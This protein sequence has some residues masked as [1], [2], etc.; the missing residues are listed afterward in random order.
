MQKSMREEVERM[1]TQFIFKQHELETTNRKPPSSVRPH[2]TFKG[3]P[4]TPM[5]LPSQIRGWN[6]SVANAYQS[7]PTEDI[8]KHPALSGNT[9]YHPKVPYRSP[10]RTKKPNALPG[11]HNAFATS[12]P[13]RPSQQRLNIAKQRAIEETQTRDAPFLSAFNIPVSPPSSPMHHSHFSSTNQPKN[14]PDEPALAPSLDIDKDVDMT[15]DGDEVMLSEETADEVDPVEPFNWKIELNRIILTETLPPFTTP[16]FQNII[17]AVASLELPPDT[18][19]VYSAGCSQILE[20]LSTTFRHNEFKKALNDISHSL[21]TMIPVISNARLH[22][23]LAALYGL[24]TTLCYALPDFSSVLLMCSQDE[25]GSSNIIVHICE[26]IRD[27]MEGS[28]KYAHKEILSKEVV[29]LLEALCFHTKDELINRLVIMPRTQASLLALLHSYQP[30]WLLI[31]GVRLLVLL[32]TYTPLCRTLISMVDT[33]FPHI[34]QVVTPGRSPLVERLCYHLTE[35]YRKDTECQVLKS[36]I[37]TFFALL[38]HSDPEVHSA[39]V[40]SAIFIPTIIIFISQLTTP[41]WDDSE[42]L[43]DASSHAITLAIKTLNQALFLLHYLI[44]NTTPVFNLKQK[45]SSVNGIRHFNGLTHTFIVTFGR[46]CYADTPGWVN[47]EGSRELVL[48]TDMARE[49]LDLVVDGPECDNIWQAY[50]IE[51]DNG[52]QTDEEELEA[53][54]LGKQ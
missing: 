40:G 20:T 3:A 18:G 42:E 6:Q 35:T 23:P 46:L 32:A 30:T 48:L 36:S 39:L 43:I 44:F 54:L 37:L 50:H 27:H 11:F 7:V 1:K 13:I 41:I 45:L 19:H 38:S 8:P 49:I 9:K 21:S 4:S 53:N 14:A 5:S 16:S 25:D 24:L 47:Q 12:T 2:R 33:N 51:H 52:S 26:T 34:E 17:E 28:E 31:R 10:E 15:V 29:S 22:P